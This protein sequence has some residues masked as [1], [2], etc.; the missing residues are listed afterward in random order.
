[1]STSHVLIQLFPVPSAGDIFFFV[2]TI[3]YQN[4][5]EFFDPEFNVK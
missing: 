1:M 4:L 2:R 3:R 5:D